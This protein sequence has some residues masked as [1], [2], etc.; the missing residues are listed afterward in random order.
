MPRATALTR[1]D[2]AVRDRQDSTEIL[3]F[4]SSNTSCRLVAED[5]TSAP[6]SESMLAALNTIAVHFELGHAVRILDFEAEFLTPNEAAEVLGVSRPTILNLIEAGVLTAE[7]VPGSSHRRIP[8]VR[9]EAFLQERAQF[10]EGMNSALAIARGSGL[11]NFSP[12]RSR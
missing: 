8:Q 5:G 12:R 6:I 4:T 1:V 7:N 9:V 10:T 3:R 11:A 2:P